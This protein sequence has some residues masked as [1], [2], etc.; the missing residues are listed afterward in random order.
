[1]AQQY[2]YNFAVMQNAQSQL[3]RLIN[4]LNILQE[5]MQRARQQVVQQWYGQASEVFSASCEKILK[6]FQELIEDYSSDRENLRQ[7]IQTYQQLEGVQITKVE[8][9]ESSNIF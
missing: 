8:E 3:N 1:M 7:A 6:Q 9:L 4:D 5:K 2:I